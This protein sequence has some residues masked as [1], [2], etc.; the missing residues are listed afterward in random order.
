MVGKLDKAMY[1]MR[2]APAAW[3]A[4]LEKTMIELGFRPVVSTPCLY[5]HPLW[6]I[7]VVGH[8]D[9]LMCVGPR[10]GLDTFMAKLQCV[11]ELTSAFLGPDAV[12]EQEG[13]FLGRSICWRTNGVTWTGNLELVKEA[14]DE[15]DMC[16]AKEVE[17][18]G[19][20][21]VY[22]VQIFLN[23]DLMS[24]ESAAKYRRTAAKL[25]YLALWQ[26]LDCVRVKRSFQV[27]ERTKIRRRSEIEVNIEITVKETCNDISLRVAGSSRRI[28]RVHRQ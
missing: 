25:N 16:E 2:D 28:D 10:S 1:G 24:K 15:W 4:E 21:E 19:M 23:A 5:Y 3:Q 26:A 17:M 22:D 9:D 6:R 18:P 8:V 7:R 27:F 14:L 13:Q 12:E 11:Y 20:T